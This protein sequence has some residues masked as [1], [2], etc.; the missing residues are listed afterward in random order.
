MHIKG[1]LIW[2]MVDSIYL[3]EYLEKIFEE[4]IDA[5]SWVKEQSALPL[6]QLQ[7]EHGQFGEPLYRVF[8]GYERLNVLLG[9]RS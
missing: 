7:A 8:R 3:R 5:V 4:K 9:R 2:R 1:H 6:L